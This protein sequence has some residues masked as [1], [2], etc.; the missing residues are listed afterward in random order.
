[1]GELTQDTYA[2]TTYITSENIKK[3]V[4]QSPPG[5][6]PYLDFCL[7]RKTFDTHWIQEKIKITNWY[8]AA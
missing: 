1:L 3:R 8:L 4:L 7:F 6:E 2:R 5:K